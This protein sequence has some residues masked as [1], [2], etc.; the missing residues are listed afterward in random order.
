[1]TSRDVQSEGLASARNMSLNVLLV[2]CC[3]RIV[4]LF[5]HCCI[6]HALLY[7]S[8]MLRRSQF[9]TKERFWLI[10]PVSRTPLRR[11]CLSSASPLAIKG[12]KE[13]QTFQNTFY[14]I[15]AKVSK[16]QI[17]TAQRFCFKKYVLFYIEFQN[18]V[19]WVTIRWTWCAK[20]RLVF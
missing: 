12:L 14:P 13:V 20:Q 17:K 4:V 7:C 2:M 11:K 1:M 5:T 9:L 19:S 3:S 16:I 6:V 15:C 18:R 10:Q 8:R